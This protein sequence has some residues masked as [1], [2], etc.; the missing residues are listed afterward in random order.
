MLKDQL[1]AFAGSGQDGRRG[2]SQVYYE[3]FTQPLGE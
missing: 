3:L 1:K 2:Q